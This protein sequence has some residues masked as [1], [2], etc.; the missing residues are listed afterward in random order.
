MQLIFYYINTVHHNILQL[1]QPH[2][3]IHYI[4]GFSNIS[5]YVN[6]TEMLMIL[7]GMMAMAHIFPCYFLNGKRI[8][9]GFYLERYMGVKD[10]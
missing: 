7:C 9:C 10:E 3:F 6:A 5:L 2:V 1:N 4:N 8:D